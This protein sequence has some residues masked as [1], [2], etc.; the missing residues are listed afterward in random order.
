MAKRRKKKSSSL[1]KLIELVIFLYISVFIIFFKVIF[2]CIQY[3]WKSFEYI[4]KESLEFF[5]ATYRKNGIVQKD[6]IDKTVKKEINKDEYVKEFLKRMGG[7]YFDLRQY[8]QI[9]LVYKS[10]E[11]EITTRSVLI[12]GV[13]FKRDRQMYGHQY[14]MGFCDLRKEFRMFKAKRIIRLVDKETG[15]IIETLKDCNCWMLNVIGS[16]IQ[17]R[18]A[19]RDWKKKMQFFINL[20]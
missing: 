14:L 16:L 9:E 4:V 7:M 17:D 1:S 3:L 2:W 6:E 13:F 10:A 5:Y 12:H 8:K 15:E 18:L 11:G 19:Q 20:C